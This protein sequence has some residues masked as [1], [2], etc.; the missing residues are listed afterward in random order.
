MNDCVRNPDTPIQKSYSHKID[1]LLNA[2]VWG[3]FI[4]LAV[5]FVV[6]GNIFMGKLSTM[7]PDW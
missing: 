6:S 3:Y 2:N 7:D 5:L 4:F 1:S